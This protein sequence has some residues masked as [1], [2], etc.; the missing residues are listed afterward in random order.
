M[1]LWAKTMDLVL[2]IPELSPTVIR[3]LMQGLHL[4]EQEAWQHG[5]IMGP[6]QIVMPR[7]AFLLPVIQVGYLDQYLLELLP[8][9]I[10]IPRL[11]PRFPV[12]L[13]VD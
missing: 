3:R 4:R 5:I 9:V 7:E 11:Q 6:S 2:V 12:P 1:G 10:G 8:I 13:A